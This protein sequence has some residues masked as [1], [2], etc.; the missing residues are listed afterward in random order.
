[1]KKII[2]STMVFLLIYLTTFPLFFPA[3]AN[4]IP[5]TITCEVKDE[6]TDGFPDLIFR[7]SRNSIGVKGVEIN[8]TSLMAS[9]K[10]EPLL[11][12]ETDET[13]VCVFHNMPNGTYI[14]SASEGTPNQG[15]VFVPLNNCKLSAEDILAINFLALYWM[16]GKAEKTRAFFANLS[17][18]VGYDLQEHPLPSS[19]G[20]SLL[21]FSRELFQWTQGLDEHLIDVR[22]NYPELKVVEPAVQV[23]KSVSNY[24]FIKALKKIR[25]TEIT[26]TKFA[27]VGVAGSPDVIDYV[28]IYQRLDITIRSEVILRVPKK[29][30]AFGAVT[31]LAGIFVSSFDIYKEFFNPDSKWNLAIQSN[32]KTLQIEAELEIASDFIGIM[33]GCIFL[34]ENLATASTG[35]LSLAAKET[36]DVVANSLGTVTCIIIA[37]VTSLE[38]YR[39]YPTLQ[40]FLNDLYTLK[41]TLI[42]KLATIG[43]ALSGAVIGFYLLAAGE[44]TTTSCIGAV[45]GI[46]LIIIGLL[47][48]Y[49]EYKDAISNLRG[50]L[51]KTLTELFKTREGLYSINTG[52]LKEEAEAYANLADIIKK[53]AEIP[54]AP[55]NM[56]QFFEFSSFRLNE[57]S[58]NDKELANAVEEARFRFDGWLRKYLKWDGTY[59]DWLGEHE[60]HIRAHLVGHN[61]TLA[62]YTS[63]SESFVNN[64]IIG[65]SAD[66][67]YHY[68]RKYITADNL[69]GVYDPNVT[70]S[71]IASRHFLWWSGW[72]FDPYAEND[73]KGN[74]YAVTYNINTETGQGS[75]K[76][77]P[78]PD[79]LSYDD[80][81]IV[82]R[83]GRLVTFYQYKFYFDE[84][85]TNIIGLP[86]RECLEA[87]QNHIKENYTLWVKPSLEKVE[88]LM[89]KLSYTPDLTPPK[90]THLVLPPYSEDDLG[91][92]YIT[93]STPILL[94][95]TDNGTGVALTAYKIFNE[96]YEL[97][98]FV[99]PSMQFNG[100]SMIVIPRFLYNGVYHI[101]YYSVDFAGNI[102]SHHYLTIVLA[103]PPPDVSIDILLP[104]MDNPAL[105]GDPSNPIPIHVAILS[106]YK[107]HNVRVKI[108]NVECPYEIVDRWTL[109][110]NLYILKIDTPPQPSEGLY[111]LN[112]T[113]SY[114]NITCFDVEEKAV[115]Y[116]VIRLAEPIQKGLAWLRT[117]QSSDGS[118][119]GEVGVT[120]LAV[121]A[122]L[123]AG[124]DERDATVK[125]A[126]N[127]ILSNV[128]SDGSIYRSYPTY[129]TSLAT[130]AL[131]A[132][133]NSIYKDIIENAK[134]WLIN[135][136]W[137][138]SCLWGSVSKDHWYYGG[139]GYGM[140]GWYR[141][142]LSNTQ[143]AAL[144]L[145]A[146]GL[147]QDDPAWKKLQ[148]FLHRCQKVN[149]SITLTIDGE[150]YTVEHWNYDG[151]VGGYDGGFMYYPGTSLAGDQK[152]Y[153]SM[154]GAGIW[155]LL[156]SGVPK[157]DPR[158]TAAMNWVRNHYTWDINPGIGWWRPYYYYLSM[159]KALTMYGEPIIDE[160]DWYQELYDK[161]TGMQVEISE[162]EGYWSTSAEDFD[163]ELTTAYAIL[164]LQTRITTPLTQRLSYLT[165]IL[166]SNCLLRVID[167]EGN[168][169]G[170][171]FTTGSGENQI[172]TAIYS[173]PFSKPQYIII[174]N[175]IAGTY[176]LELIGVSNGTF[177][178]TIQGN[179]GEEVTD[180]F[181]YEGKISPGELYSS[182]I[183]VTAI[184][185]PI[186]IYSKPPEFQEI[187]DDVPPTTTLQIGE[188]KYIDAMANIY[189]SSKTEFT[190]TAEDNSE[191]SILAIFYRIHND[192]YDTGLIEYSA[193]FN[194]TELPDGKY[195]MDYYSI[196]TLGNT[197][198]T[199]VVSII[200]DN[201]PPRTATPEGGTYSRAVTVTLI[202]NDE[203]CGVKEI[204]YKI[205]EEGA[206]TKYTGAFNLTEPSTYT[207]Y[208]Y[209]VD[210]LGNKEEVRS[211][212][213]TIR[214][215]TPLWVWIAIVI[216][217]MAVIVVATLIIR[218]KKVR[219]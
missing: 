123:N 156:L 185:G 83:N 163:P 40:R 169:L 101:A 208:Y 12:G 138:E 215:P 111:D 194:I 132:T 37:L 32:D 85:T 214:S 69:D 172:P 176:E 193:P 184:V 80:V 118:W 13:G 117:R 29:V 116:A 104:S 55:Q 67:S 168:A 31:A 126:I 41:P 149:F 110:C 45:V 74:S 145:D 7:A 198:K 147:P 140:S 170:Y 131:V 154:T 93:S 64:A 144:A 191:T 46:I 100:W 200:L 52:Y 81:R 112:V 87:W 165:F 76:Y 204:Y 58:E 19:E 77:E 195:S 152:S 106:P 161:I 91:N 162:E 150:E 146:A 38:L 48:M 199:N 33:E 68:Q 97:G 62:N 79:Y 209:A 14:W 60:G 44:V 39:K 207:I 182:G 11:K 190:L 34:F 65:I 175:P 89:K 43:V 53:I 158:I 174:I 102:E 180:T 57:Y 135:S 179:Y 137:D 124:Y 54:Q 139:F 15:T 1:M 130:I 128:R 187:I 121:L 151:S 82:K 129:E 166:K 16:E 78:K 173:S 217:A 17:K 3:L 178:L 35:G 216:A 94:S 114:K 103:N 155:S 109:V 10:S 211:T 143:F 105:A 98:W 189:V 119:R 90:T 95:A 63:T 73:T 99:E 23:F 2:L 115:E 50:E 157:S 141:P 192:S 183:T 188:P 4:T 218:R 96:T 206:W 113:A 86:V 20:K 36:L 213:Y 66:G 202:A 25:L 205:G 24:M 26:L 201:T 167:P 5:P 171:N 70:Y 108:G 28:V 59:K 133:H 18:L 186:D 107:I 47:T 30:A 160:H 21:E 159:S 51:G 8:V 148:V 153:G 212:T 88:E 84:G 125:N 22:I 42:L 164:S 142:D 181:T 92:I 61:C 6:N 49:F 203:G 75:F 210:N 219:K 71:K 120:S 72:A 9:A 197:E 27:F 196:D 56:K 127:Y 136:Q 122:F 134:N 177:E